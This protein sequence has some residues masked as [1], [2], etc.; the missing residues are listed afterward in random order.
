MRAWQLTCQNMMLA[1]LLISFILLIVPL[2]ILAKPLLVLGMELNLL[3]ARGFL[4]W[5]HLP[6]LEV[7][8][9]AFDGGCIIRIRAGED[10]GHPQPLDLRKRLWLGIV[11]GVVHQDQG[12]LSP[13]GILTI[14]DG[15]QLCQEEQLHLVIR[16]DL[17]QGEEELPLS[18]NG[19]DE[20]DSRMYL[21]GVDAIH[22]SSLSPAP[23]P[24]VLQIDPGLVHIDDALALL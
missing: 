6:L 5:Y 17:S 3:L 7:S 8:E 12:V 19:S 11:A 20:G 10:D 16:I 21:L 23:P 14:E 15:G 22:D 18:T 1:V 24:I 13:E 2:T 9:E 4:L